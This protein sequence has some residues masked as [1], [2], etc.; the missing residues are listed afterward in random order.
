MKYII[1][2]I[3]VSLIIDFATTDEFARFREEMESKVIWIASNM[4]KAY[5]KRYNQDV[6]NC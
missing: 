2:L 1:S 5:Q 4:T 6:R 3:V